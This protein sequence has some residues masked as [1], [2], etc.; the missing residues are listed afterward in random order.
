MADTLAIMLMGP[1]SLTPSRAR[2]S[3]GDF[4]AFQVSPAGAI[5][6][7]SLASAVGMLICA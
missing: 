4:T 2:R 5:S 1:F 6:G 7:C 3:E